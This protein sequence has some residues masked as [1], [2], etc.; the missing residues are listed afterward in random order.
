V[1]GHPRSLARR[2]RLAGRR[3]AWRLGG[4]RRARDAAGRIRLHL[5]CGEER[6][7]GYVNV[8]LS[9]DAE[10]DL[11]IDFAAIGGVFPAGTVSEAVL[12][13]SLS[14]LTLWEAR[15]LLRDLHRLLAPGGSIVLELPDLAKCAARAIAS[16]GD[17]SDYI[18]AVR[19]F[20]AFGLDELERRE[21]YRPYAFGWASWHLVREMER[22]GFREVKVLEPR[23][24]GP[25]PWR[26]V[27][28]EAVK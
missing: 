19:G 17:E 26:D 28:I 20:Y 1:P 5:G 13:H 24:H 25:R 4:A 9:P 12:I 23:T 6:W 16:E 27:R 10:S 11:R 15:D 7:A 3:L 14:Y 22:A 18:E 8:D 21:R 2:V